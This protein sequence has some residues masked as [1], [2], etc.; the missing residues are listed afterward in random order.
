MLKMFLVF[1]L[2]YYIGNGLDTPLFANSDLIPGYK[3]DTHARQLLGGNHG[4]QIESSKNIGCQWYSRD[5]D[6]TFSPMNVCWCQKSDNVNPNCEMVTCNNDGTGIM[7][8]RYENDST[9]KCESEPTYAN[10]SNIHG[11][12]SCNNEGYMG[13]TCNWG[14]IQF[15]DQNDTDNTTCTKNENHFGSQSYVLN[16][17]LNYT[18]MNSMEYI[19]YNIYIYIF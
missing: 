13:S 19:N 16:S 14:V 7:H 12:Y 2:L 18:N 6:E 8:T 5:Y 3:V 15:M 11:F 10:S 17:C 9:G 4:L 1:C